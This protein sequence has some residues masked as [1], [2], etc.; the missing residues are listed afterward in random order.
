M[1]ASDR[2][3]AL[4]RSKLA[5]E[6]SEE[7]RGVLSDSMTLRDLVDGEV[8]VSEGAVDNRLYVIVDGVLS[9]VKNAGSAEQVTFF[10]I[11][12][13]EFADEL[14]FLD[15]TQ[16]YASLVACGSTRVLGLEREKLEGL[17]ESRPDIVYRV[18]RA[19]VRAVHQI[20]R[21]LSMQSVELTNYIYKQHGRY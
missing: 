7:Q 11:G 17:L 10:T 18:M 9:V 19:I 12:A 15:G 20:Q 1:V 21:R 14:S 3:D 8:L 6:L 5:A 4:S 2:L 13:G 16:H